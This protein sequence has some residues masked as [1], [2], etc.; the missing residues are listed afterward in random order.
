MADWF[1]NFPEIK[2]KRLTLDELRENDINEI[3]AIFSDPDVIQ[4]YDVE[5]FKSPSEAE[6]L[7]HYF[8]S[9]FDK[10]QAI[11]WAIRPNGS[12]KLIGSCGFTSWNEFDYSAIVGYDLMP[13]HWGKGYAKE[14]V[15][16]ILA[17]AFS[18]DFPFKVNRIESVIM[19]SNRPSISLCEKLGFQFEGTLRE[20]VYCDGQFH[21][22]N[23]YSLLRI[24]HRAN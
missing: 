18:D 7:I 13:A 12:D 1:T 11:R 14:A 20:K 9:R 8:Q 22:M 21:D 5:Q 16:A 19:P 24:D 15:S 17:L 2:T 23:L 4:H 10:N 6:H 3:F